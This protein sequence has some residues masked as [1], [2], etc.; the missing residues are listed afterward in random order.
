MDLKHANSDVK[1]IN[2]SMS[3]IGMMVKS[4]E[5]LLLMLYDLNIDKYAK[6]YIIKCYEHSH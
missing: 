6:S 1:F 5:L 4:S 2:F 3:T